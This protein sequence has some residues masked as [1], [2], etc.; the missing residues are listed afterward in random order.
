[1]ATEATHTGATDNYDLISR[2]N[3]WIIALAIIMMTGVGFFLG[4]VMERGPEKAALLGT[5]KAVG[6][7]VL[8]YGLWRVGYRLA[9]GFKADAAPMPA[10][11]ARAAHAVHWI[12]LAAI[13]IMPVSGIAGSYFRGRATEVFGLFTIPAGPEI[14]VLSGAASATHDFMAL[15]LL[16]ALLLHIGGALKHHL[17]DKDTTLLRMIGRA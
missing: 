2:I 15:I 1:M 17:I 6:V 3:H 12:L 14:E 4:R 11:Q 5:H 8:I 9:Q 7:L 16:A 10:W 13:L